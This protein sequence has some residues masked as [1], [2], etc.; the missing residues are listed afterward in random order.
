[1][2]FIESIFAENGVFVKVGNVPLYAAH[3]LL[4]DSGRLEHFI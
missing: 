3:R 2:Y 1:M 4:E